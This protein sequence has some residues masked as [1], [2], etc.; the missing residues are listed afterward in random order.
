MPQSEECGFHKAGEDLPAHWLV[1]CQN[2]KSVRFLVDCISRETAAA[3]DVW[4]AEELTGSILE[5]EG[6]DSSLDVNFEAQKLMTLHVIP[7]PLG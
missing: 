6:I 5:I 7:R 2:R 3:I 4:P 1:N